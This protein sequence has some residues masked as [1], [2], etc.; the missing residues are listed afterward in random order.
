[1]RGRLLSFFGIVLF[2]L[3]WFRFSFFKFINWLNVLGMFCL[4]WL[5][6]KLSDFS[7]FKLLML[8]MMWLLRW[9][10]FRFRDVSLGIF[11]IDKGM[12]FVSWFFDKFMLVRVVVVGYLVG[13]LFWSDELVIVS[14]VSWVNLEMMIFI[15][16]VLI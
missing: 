5:M 15:F 9:L 3:L 13:R 11:V 12:G 10:W 7:L 14:L 8:L 4:S 2:S 6:F 16:V 1:M